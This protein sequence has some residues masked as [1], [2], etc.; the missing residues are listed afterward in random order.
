MF[1]TAP[2]DGKPSADAPDSTGVSGVPAVIAIDGPAGAGKSTVSR[3]L[4]RRLGFVLL[5]TGALYRSLALLAHDEGIA[6][7]DEVKLAERAA[8]MHVVFEEAPEV[9]GTGQRVVVDGR[10]LT[11][12]IR[13]T[14]VSDG[15]SQVSAL[16]AVREALLSVQRAVARR[17]RCVVEGRDIG[18]VVL[19]WAPVKFFLTASVEERARRRYLELLARGLP[20]DLQAVA[21]EIRERDRRDRTRAIAPLRQADDALLVDTSSLGIDEV[22]ARMERQARERLRL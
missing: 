2:T 16:P 3:E 4:A 17:G 12:A 7:N 21:D 19:P 10:D 15:A 6:W 1:A 20:S 18:T 8:R 22:V 5:D 14:L 11:S 9:P 13:T